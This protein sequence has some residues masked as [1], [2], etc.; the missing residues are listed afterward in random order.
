[1]TSDSRLVA[2]PLQ[3]VVCQ[4]CGLGANGSPTL[5]A[6]LDRYYQEDYQLNCHTPQAEHTFVIDGHPRTRSQVIYDWI[7]ALLDGSGVDLTTAS[8]LE[9]GCGSGALLAHFPTP[10]K[11]GI[12]M[13]RQ[14]VALATEKGLTVT[15]GSYHDVSGTYDLI[16]SFGVIEHVV[17][18]TDFLRTLRRA[19]K[20]GGR[21]VLGQPIQDAVSYD[22]FFA[23]HLHHFFLRHLSAY[24]EK[25]GWVEQHRLVGYGPMP[26][27]SLHLLAAGQEPT[28]WQFG[29]P[30][31]GPRFELADFKAQFAALDTYLAERQPLGPIYAYGASE[32]LKLFEANTRLT[33]VVSGVIDDFQPGALKLDQLTAP[34]TGSLTFVLTMNPL[35]QEKVAE[36]LRQ[37]FPEAPIYSVQRR[38]LV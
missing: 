10:H 8:L 23:D 37:R 20:P 29:N 22:V 11:Q 35:Y 1:M 4:G 30:L 24:F 31:A 33:E 9:V 28:K 21:L 3:K 2:I 15:A 12:E 14:A 16:V 34:A 17:S 5:L 36:Q 18:P 13:S 26:N 38:C 7:T 19:L 27:F 6:D 32:C 25:T